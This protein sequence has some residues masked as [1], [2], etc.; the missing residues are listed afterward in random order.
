MRI[1]AIGNSQPTN[2]QAFKS[3]MP[4][5]QVATFLSTEVAEFRKSIQPISNK[6]QSVFQQVCDSLSELT[7]WREFLREAEAR[8]Q[9]DLGTQE[10]VSFSKVDAAL[11]DFAKEWDLRKARE[12]ILEN[13]SNT[14]PVEKFELKAGKGIADASEIDTVRRVIAENSTDTAKKRQADNVATAEY[15]AANAQS[16]TAIFHYFRGII[17]HKEELG[18]PYHARLKALFQE[19]RQSTSAAMAAR[20]IAY[21]SEGKRWP[22]WMTS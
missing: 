4:N 8:I 22:A 9:K 21:S 18:G 10:T 13:I 7:K 20:K 19:L 16:P 15:L 1:Y 11:S 17:E 5:K 3:A 6:G 12:Y 2:N 14:A